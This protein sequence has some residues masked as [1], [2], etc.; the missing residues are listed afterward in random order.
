MQPSTRIYVL[1]KLSQE[2]EENLIL[3][4]Q[5]RRPLWDVSQPV[6]QRSEQTRRRLW[7]EV[8]VELNGVLDAAAVQKKFKSLRDTHRKIIQSEQ[9]LP[10]GSGRN[11]NDEDSHKWKNYDVIEFL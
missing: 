6:E 4:V 3:S 1:K 9:Y 10:S 7:E 5:N 8:A 11:E 2:E